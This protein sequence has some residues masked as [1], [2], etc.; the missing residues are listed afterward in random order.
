MNLT[1]ADTP[2]W[3]TGTAGMAF[4]TV[5]ERDIIQVNQ[6]FTSEYGPSY[7]YRLRSADG[8]NVMLVAEHDGEVLAFARAVRLLGYERAW[9]F[10][11][12]IVHPRFRGRHVAKRL[13]ELRLEAV[14]TRGGVLAVSEPVCYR[15][16]CASQR[17][18]VDRGFVLC[19]IL[20]F[21]YPDIHADL[22]G[23]Q[24]ESMVVAVRSLRDG[25]DISL[26]HRRVHLPNGL[27]SLHNLFLPRF[28]CQ[29]GWGEDVLGS[30]PAVIEHEPYHLGGVDGSRFVDVPVNWPGAEDAV[31]TYLALGYRF[32]AILPGFGITPDGHVHDLVRLYKPPEISH[33][34]FDKIHVAEPL[35]RLHA[36]M[37]RE[38]DTR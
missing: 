32:A 38:Y 13:L 37:A 8:P 5:E 12:L 25:E 29:R 30:M 35:R 21:K 14:I 19:G 28:V 23:A 17:N 22:L 31:Q 36:F 2:L 20:P 26:G 24:P 16:D 3:R 10:G 1:E 6:L 18:L 34:T 4:R 9:E 11:G 27:P 15:P 7:P 33:L